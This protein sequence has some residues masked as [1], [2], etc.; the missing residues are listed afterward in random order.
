VLQRKFWSADRRKMHDEIKRAEKFL[1]DPRVA[2]EIGGD[3]EIR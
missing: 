1:G 2:V 3:R